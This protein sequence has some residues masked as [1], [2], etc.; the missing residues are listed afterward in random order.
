MGAFGK[1]LVFGLSECQIGDLG[2]IELSRG[3]GNGSM[4]A[5]TTLWLRNIDQTKHCVE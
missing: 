5:L 4:G 3:I 1:L 2:M